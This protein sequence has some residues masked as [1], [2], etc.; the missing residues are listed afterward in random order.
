VRGDIAIHGY[1]YDVQTG[2]LV[3]VPEATRIGRP[4]SSA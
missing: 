4:Q 2:R 3:D 1:V